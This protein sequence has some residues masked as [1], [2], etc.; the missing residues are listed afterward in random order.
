VTIYERNQYLLH[1]QEGNLIRYIHPN[2]AEWPAPGSGYPLTRLPFMNWRADYAGEIVEAIRKQ[3]ETFQRL[4][5]CKIKVNLNSKMERPIPSGGGVEISDNNLGSQQYDFAV[6]AVGYGSE[7]INVAV[8]PSYWRNDDFAQPCGKDKPLRYLV[9]GTGDGGLV[10][11]LRLKLKGFQHKPFFENIVFKKWLLD[12]KERQE[13]HGWEGLWGDNASIREKF[14]DFF[15][16]IR[17]D[18]EVV[19]NS[20]RTAFESD[21]QMLNKLC[22]S[23]L[24]DSGEVSYIQG[25]L[26]SAENKNGK[27]ETVFDGAPTEEFDFV[28]QRQGPSSELETLFFTADSPE[29]RKLRDDWRQGERKPP[30][31]HDPAFGVEFLANE[32]KSAH[33]EH[34]YQI[35]FALASKKQAYAIAKLIEKKL[36]EVDA[37]MADLDPDR[38]DDGPIVFEWQGRN[39]AFHFEKIDIIRFRGDNLETGAMSWRKH[40][41]VP[42]QSLV[43]GTDNRAMLDYLLDDLYLPYHVIRYYLPDGFS[44]EIDFFIDTATETYLV[45]RKNCLEVHCMVGMHQAHQLLRVPTLAEAMGNWWTVRRLGGYGWAVQ[46]TSSVNILHFRGNE[47]VR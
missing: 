1:L 45:R 9:S 24:I 8:T 6:L 21:A 30:F 15:K 27:F 4:N 19:L 41:P 40:L 38:L 16:L 26:K 14:P 39:A 7:R 32:F 11:V 3:W 20:K 36:K 17:T 42:Q 44:G 28:I 5:C 35:G 2:I 10:E 46:N 22:V 37:T 25:E 47:I 31:T 18:T 33:H 43:L 29:F 23:L 13:Q 34:G 12:A